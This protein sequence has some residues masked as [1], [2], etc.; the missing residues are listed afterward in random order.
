MG[1]A[2]LATWGRGGGAGVHLVE[3]EEGPVL[4]REAAQTL[5]H[6]PPPSRPGPTTPHSRDRRAG[7]TGDRVFAASTAARP[8]NAGR[9]EA[10]E[11][12]GAVKGGV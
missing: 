2:R 12:G 11:E 7:G 9:T 8:Q 6:A 1:S 10:S 5:P 4:R 3:D